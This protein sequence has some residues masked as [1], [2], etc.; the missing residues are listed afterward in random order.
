VR[1]VSAFAAAVTLV[2]MVAVACDEG[3][4]APSTTGYRFGGASVQ[5]L[6]DEAE[7]AIREYGLGFACLHAESAAKEWKVEDLVGLAGL[8]GIVT[9]PAVRA[10]RQ[11]EEG[12]VLI[13]IYQQGYQG[14]VVS[15]MPSAMRMVMSDGT[16]CYGPALS[17][18]PL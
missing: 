12:N 7:G 18:R 17:L 10:A 6:M 13:S 5:N 2:G 11:T 8:S 15:T 1:A 14:G 16:V 4:S 3:P 9:N